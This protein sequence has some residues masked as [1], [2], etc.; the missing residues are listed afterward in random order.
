MYSKIPRFHEKLKCTICQSTLERRNMEVHIASKHKEVDPKKWELHCSED[1]KKRKRLD[2]MWKTGAD[3]GASSKFAHLSAEAIVGGVFTISPAPINE[4]A[5]AIV[6]SEPS[7]LPID[8]LNV[9]TISEAPASTTPLVRPPI[10]STTNKV[11]DSEFY[12]SVKFS[13]TI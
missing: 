11:S 10:A 7:V 5:M 13:A 3:T 1:G 6:D 9:S 2:N 12:I 4:Q 8:Q